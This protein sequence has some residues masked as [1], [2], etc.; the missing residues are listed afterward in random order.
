MHAETERT[1]RR[2]LP[3][4]VGELLQRHEQRRRVRRASWNVHVKAAESWRSRSERIAAEAA[5]R[6][7]GVDIDAAGLEM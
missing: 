6:S 1:E 3:D 7:A 2:L 5:T 4:V